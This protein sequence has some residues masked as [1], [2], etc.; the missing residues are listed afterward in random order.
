[1]NAIERWFIERKG[2]E[3]LQNLFSSL[4]GKKTHI[5]AIVGALT[6]I[7]GHFWGPVVIHGNQVIPA[8]DS[9]TMWDIIWNGGLFSALRM[10]VSAATPPQGETK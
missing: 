9:K 7:V 10:G 4:Q 1:M 5:L 3:M 2:N 8:I 6:A